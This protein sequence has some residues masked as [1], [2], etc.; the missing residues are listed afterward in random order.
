MNS[1]TGFPLACA[2]LAPGLRLGLHDRKSKVSLH[3][4]KLDLS[5][6]ASTACYVLRFSGESQKAL[7]RTTEMPKQEKYRL[8]GQLLAQI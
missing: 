5:K 8:H 6:G 3:V 4:Q 7:L 2:W 1:G